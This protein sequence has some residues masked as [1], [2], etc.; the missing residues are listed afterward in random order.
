MFIIGRS[1]PGRSDFI[2]IGVIQ[3]LARAG[4][5]GYIAGVGRRNGAVPGRIRRPESPVMSRNGCT[6]DR[7]HGSVGLTL[8]AVSAH[9]H[10]GSARLGHAAHGLEA[11][12]STKKNTL[13]YHGFMPYPGEGFP[14][15]V[16]HR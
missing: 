1:V 5:T 15:G 2:L 6:K 12:W 8:P 9:P 11:G 7:G 16:L 3:A 13:G 14:A 4:E 10:G